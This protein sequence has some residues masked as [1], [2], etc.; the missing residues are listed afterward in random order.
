MHLLLKRKEKI[1]EARSAAALELIITV[2]ILG[3]VR[4]TPSELVKAVHAVLNVRHSKSTYSRQKIQELI[5]E[6]YLRKTINQGEEYLEPTAK[7]AVTA[8]KYVALSRTVVT[9]PIIA[10]A[11][12]LAE[13][14]APQLTTPALLTTLA[15]YVGGL[16]ALTW[17]PPPSNLNPKLTAKL[18]RTVPIAITLQ[19]IPHYVKEL[20]KKTSGEAD[21]NPRKNHQQKHREERVPIK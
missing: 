10:T 5:R 4:N 19:Y 11:A 13:T 2:T 20:L 17:L 18:A 1:E 16:A 21:A 9:L 14:I 7:G 6:G 8:G 15:L 12:L 3:K